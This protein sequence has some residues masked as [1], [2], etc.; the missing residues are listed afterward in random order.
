M[1]TIGEHHPSLADEVAGLLWAV[2][3]DNWDGGLRRMA[4]NPAPDDLDRAELF[5]LYREEHVHD[6]E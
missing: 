4:W 2:I 1:W 6:D 5:T 3:D